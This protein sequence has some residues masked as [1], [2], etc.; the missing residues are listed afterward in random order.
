M[1]LPALN[2]EGS[3]PVGQSETFWQTQNVAIEASSSWKQSRLFP[4][5]QMFSDS[6]LR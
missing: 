5:P 3:F 4:G 1:N 2:A 6:V